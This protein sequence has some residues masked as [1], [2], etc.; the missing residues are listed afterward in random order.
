MMNVI[1]TEAT[2]DAEPVVIGGAVAALGIDDLFVLD[3]IGHLAA[4]AAVRAKGVHLSVGVGYALLH[5]VEHDGRHQRA[6][7]TGLDAFAAG[8]AGGFA[9]R[10]V[11]IEHD[12]RAVIAPG[13]ADNVVHLHL[14]AGT[15]A[16]PALD[17]SVEVD[18][19]RRMAGVC[20]RAFGCGKAAARD[21]EPV[22]P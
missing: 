14:A 5:V 17:A 7:R 10:I 9:H 15:H 11:E 1:K 16:Q 12:L 8:D 19:H 13:H 20:N 3:L 22:R 21:L 18:A 4:D 2:L 6:G